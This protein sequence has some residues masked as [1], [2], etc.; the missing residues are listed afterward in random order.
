MRVLTDAGCAAQRVLLDE[1][2]YATAPERAAS[3]LL[4]E[5]PGPW[6]SVGWPAD[7]PDAAR[8]ALALATELWVRPQLI[9]PLRDRRSR[10]CTVMVASCRP[11]RR[12]LERRELRDP[13]ELAGL[14][15]EA[16][17]AGDPPGFGQRST[18]PVVLVCTH[19]RRDV[20]CA[21][22]GRP[23]AQALAAELSGLVWETTHVGGDRFAPNV[24]TLPHGSYHGGAPAA[25]APA[26]AAAA[27]GGD[28]V[29]PYLRGIA[30]TPAAAQAAEHVVRRELGLASLDAVRAVDVVQRADAVEEVHVQAVSRRFTVW[31]HRRRLPDVRL[32][33]C[34][35]KGVHDRPYVREV[36]DFVELPQE[37]LA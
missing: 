31:M 14:D 15:L 25:A 7:L 32:T 1:P 27:L 17:A 34:A 23:L 28:V 33:S 5:H 29:L 24:V 20:C 19:G 21:R 35:G 11:G 30:G 6:P 12:W 37:V 36:V 18:R 10:A 3:W 13:A 4:I 26:L 2:L 8:T 22:R 9:R 16:V